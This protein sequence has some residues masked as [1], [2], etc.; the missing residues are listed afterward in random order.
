[1][2]DIGYQ[3]QTFT[4]EL[5]SAAFAFLLADKDKTQRIVNDI[6][7][8]FDPSLSVNAVLRVEVLSP[9]VQSGE[10]A[11]QKISRISSD[12]YR[13][14]LFEIIRTEC[15]ID[16]TNDDMIDFYSIMIRMD[17]G[18]CFSLT[19]RSSCATTL[20]SWQQSN[21]CS[22]ASSQLDSDD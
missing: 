10:G 13:Q 14:R 7:S 22:V 6:L 9:I 12:E 21:D 3:L 19:R 2:L 16:E 20:S 18:Q 1:M 15:H 4:I 11:L 5:Q 8:K 17:Q